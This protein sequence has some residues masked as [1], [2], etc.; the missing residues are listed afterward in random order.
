MPVRDALENI[1]H[2]YGCNDSH[3]T[4][5]NLMARQTYLV[6]RGRPGLRRSSGALGDRKR[7]ELLFVHSKLKRPFVNCGDKIEE[8]FH[9]PQF[10]S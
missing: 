1:G 10:L 5:L 4:S 6:H 7:R 8:C 3:C 9:K 2:N